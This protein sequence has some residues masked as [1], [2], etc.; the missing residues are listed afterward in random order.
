MLEAGMRPVDNYIRITCAS[1]NCNA[2]LTLDLDPCRKARPESYEKATTEGWVVGYP[3]GKTTCPK[4]IDDN[5]V[6]DIPAP[7]PW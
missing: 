6:T 3:I 2:V 7:C 1:E 4:C 5:V